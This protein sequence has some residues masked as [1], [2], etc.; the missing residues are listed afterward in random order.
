MPTEPPDYRAYLLRLWLASA[1]HNGSGAWRAS[2]ENSHTGERL[3][4]ASLEQLFAYLIEQVER[5]RHP[6]S[7]LASDASDD[8]R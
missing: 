1:E 3:G 8:H 6:L 4:F 2:L 5:T 7:K